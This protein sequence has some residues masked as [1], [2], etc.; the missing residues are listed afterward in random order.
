MKQVTV[1]RYEYS[2]VQAPAN[3]TTMKDMLKS[4]GH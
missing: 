2:G 3:A 4:R 1:A